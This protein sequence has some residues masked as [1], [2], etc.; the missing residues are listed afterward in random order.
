M[1]LIYLND[2]PIRWL[3][4]LRNNTRWVYVVNVA[5]GITDRL[6]AVA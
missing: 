4:S 1:I 5:V 6:L 2:R 3:I